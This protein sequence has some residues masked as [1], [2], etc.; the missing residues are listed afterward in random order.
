MYASQKNIQILIS[1]LKQY[2]IRYMVLSPGTRN[3]ALCHSVETDPDFKCFSMVDERSAAYFALGLC[4]S[5]GEPVCFSC[6]SSTAACNYLPAIREAFEKKLPL[7]A[8]TGD[9]EWYKLYQMEDQMIDQ[10]Y[11]YGKYCQHYSLLPKG[12]TSDEEWYCIRKVNE[13][14][15]AIKKGPIQI[16]FQ[17]SDIS[18]PIKVLPQ[19]R[20]ITLQEKPNWELIRKRLEKYNRILVICGQR[21]PHSATLSYQLR[22]FSDKYGAV[23]ATDYFSNLKDEKFLRT[24]LVTEAMSMTPH[25]FDKYCPDL[26]ISIG[27]HFWSFIKYSLR[28]NYQK[29]NHWRV[30]TD[31]AFMDGFK[32]LT[33]VFKCTPEIFFTEVN[34]TT[35]KGKDNYYRQW[36]KRLNN[37]RYPKL[38]FSNFSVIKDVVNAIPADSLVHTTILNATRLLNFQNMDESVTAYSNLGADGIDGCLSTWLGESDDYNPNEKSFLL[39]GDLSLIYD[40]SSLLNG[41]KNNQR[42]LVINNY[43]GSEFHIL[44]SRLSVPELD[45]HIAAGHHTSMK[46]VVSIN[47]NLKYICATNQSELNQAIPQFIADSDKPIVLE[48]ITDADTD[49]YMLKM[50]YS[51]NQNWKLKLKGVL[52]QKIKAILINRKK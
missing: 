3:S 13:A 23:I 44:F 31:G 43:A 46:D 9:R 35:Y 28:A 39:S 38:Q 7:I 51:L 14:L 45:W 6:T 17:V 18:F 21:Y 8:L 26:V 34:K 36:H 52:K 27:K 30:S 15:H 24:V 32:S 22:E 49:A 40:M 33:D 1:L 48:V 10:N 37:V 5:S 41:L 11:M 20:K 47:P 19:Y 4:E 50:F 16:N 42:I 25:D 12:N 2:N 29:F